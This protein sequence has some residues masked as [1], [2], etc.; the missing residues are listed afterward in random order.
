MQQIRGLETDMLEQ[1]M[2]YNNEKIEAK[3]PRT[4]FSEGKENK[5]MRET[6]IVLYKTLNSLTIHVITNQSRSI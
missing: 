4:R 3:N 1:I 5:K 2:T 6:L